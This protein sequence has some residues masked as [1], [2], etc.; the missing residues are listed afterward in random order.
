M[1]ETC[2]S[3]YQILHKNRYQVRYGY[4]KPK[5]SKEIWKKYYFFNEQCPITLQRN[6]WKAS[7]AKGTTPLSLLKICQKF[8]KFG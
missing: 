5:L 1:E 6:D 7:T 2:E 4:R 3:S 8:V